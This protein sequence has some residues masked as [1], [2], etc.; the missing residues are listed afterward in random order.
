[1]K[2]AILYIG[3]GEYIKLWKGFVDSMERF[4][5]PNYEKHY[6]VF[7]DKENIYKKEQKIVSI[8]YQED[9]G[10]PKNSLLRFQFFLR[11]ES[12]LKK[13]DYIFFM[14]ANIFCTRKIES[15]EILP[16]EESLVVVAHIDFY[17]KNPDEYTYD[18]NPV[19]KAYVPYGTGRYY[20]T[21]AVNGG[22]AEGFLQMV[23]CLSERTQQ[24]LE[25]GVIALW[26]D[27]SHLNRYIIDY[28]NYRLLM[29][30]FA[31]REGARTSFE[32]ILVARNKR[33]YFAVDRIKTG[34]DFS[35]S[36]FVSEKE[37]DRLRLN[38]LLIS[39]WAIRKQEGKRLDMYFMKKN[40]R[41]I[42]LYGYGNFG[43]FFLQEIA[44]TEIQIAYIIDKNASNIQDKRYIISENL[45]PEIEADVIVIAPVYSCYCIM[46]HLIGTAN[47][48]IVS[49]DKVIDDL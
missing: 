26:H 22:T 27:E 45:L 33:T 34:M 31:Y 20:V 17:G 19:S 10:W 36:L 4:F 47:I 21:G 14:N 2:I 49:L 15:W 37:I 42:I 16:R 8:I 1:M 6:F 23:H 38:D 35:K 12:E 11:I 13:Y 29:P 30:S 3:I 48:P 44:D 46:D 18:R 5:L 25:S 40:W 39:N 9:L 41:K 43:Q 24:D 28:P 32:R 7:T